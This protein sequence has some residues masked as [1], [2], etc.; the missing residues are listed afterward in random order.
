[1]SKVILFLLFAGTIQAQKCNLEFK[2][3]F[4]GKPLE[5]GNYKYV[6]PSGD[7][8]AIERFRFYIS[9]VQLAYTN[10]QLYSEKNSYH[11]VDAEDIESMRF[12]LADAP[13]G[14]VSSMTFNIGVDSAASVAGALS[15]AL[16]PV[17]GMYWAWN[18]GYINAKL[19]G[20][21][22][23][24]SGQKPNAFEFHIGG[25]L[26]PHYALRNVTLKFKNPRDALSI[27]V[28][29][30]AAAWL[31]G[32]ELK[33]ENSVV[34]PGEEAMRVADRYAKMFSVAE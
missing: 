9:G 2:P 30:D 32:V 1:M 6:S 12:T 15:G 4:S 10:G 8:V 16:D 3:F 34:I 14:Q 20:S 5:L 31:K 18:S 7:T 23:T 13:C 26:R 28:R 22:K 11:L 19:E 24:K 29:C 27:V 25:Y 21:C 17:K 33:K